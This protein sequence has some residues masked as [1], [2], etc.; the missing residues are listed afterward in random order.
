MFPK[1]LHGTWITLLILLLSGLIGNALAVGVA[2]G[3]VSKNPFVN[4]TS[5]FYTLLMRGT[6]LLVQI[7]LLYYGS[8][9]SSPIRPPS[10]RASSGLISGMGSGT[11]SLPSASTPRAI[12]ATCFAAG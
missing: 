4:S 2:L 8:A 3:R 7:Y 11:A 6:P 12:R 5:Y 1:L 10:G 9:A